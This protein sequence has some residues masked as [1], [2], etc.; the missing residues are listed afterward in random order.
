MGSEANGG[1][2]FSSKNHLFLVQHQGHYRNL[3]SEEGTFQ[4]CRNFIQSRAWVSS[5]LWTFTGTSPL[6]GTCELKAPLLT[7]IYATR[8]LN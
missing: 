4:G 7:F 2:M 8:Q 3:L 6:A 1:G 5:T